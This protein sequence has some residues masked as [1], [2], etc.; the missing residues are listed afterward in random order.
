MRALWRGAVVYAA[1]EPIIAMI[2]NTEIN[3]DVALVLRRDSDAYRWYEV[4]GATAA[5]E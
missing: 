2:F 5:M 3:A 1:G 4:S